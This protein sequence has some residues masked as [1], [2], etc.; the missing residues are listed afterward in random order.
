MSGKKT[1]KN[2]WVVY[3]MLYLKLKK[4]KRV[5]TSKVYICCRYV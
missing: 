3:L 1:G 5:F 4:K 2:T